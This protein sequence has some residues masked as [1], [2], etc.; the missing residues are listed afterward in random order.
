MVWILVPGALALIALLVFGGLLLADADAVVAGTVAIALLLLATGLAVNG[1][2]VTRGRERRL[3]AIADALREERADERA[4]LERHVRRLEDALS[5]ERVVLRRLRDSWRAE[6]EWSRELR[7]QLQEL[8]GRSAGRRDV[9]ELVLETAIR[10]VDAQ[11]GLLLTRQDDDDD[12]NLDL[13]TALGF[14]EDPE[15]SAV[16]QRFGREVLSE[17]QIIREDHP[18]PS[19]REATP[20]DEEIDTLVAVPLYIRD[21]FHGVIVCANRPGGF[22]EVDDEVL[23]AL[24]NHAGAALH[25]GQLGRDLRDA[26]RAVVRVLAEAVSA[27]DPVLHRESAALSLLAGELAADLGLTDDERDVLVIATLLRAV[28]YLPLPER[29]LLRPGPLTPDESALISLHPRLGYDILR[30]APALRAPATAILYHHER[31][32]GQGYPAGLQG[33]DIPIVARALAVLEAFGAM[34]HE[35]PHRGAASPERA[36]N[37]L[38]EKAGMQF[39]PEIAQL[40]VERVRTGPVH[41]GDD[42]PDAIT[43][44]LQ[45]DPA[46]LDGTSAD[47]L[48]ATTVDG[49]TLLGDHHALQRELLEAT[50]QATAERRF[51]VVLLQLQDLP[52][53]NE[54]FGYV[55]GDRLIQ[56]AARRAATV[57]TRLGATTFRA[58]GR[59]LAMQVP[60]RDGDDV[61]DILQQIRTEF[62]AGPAV[63]VVASAWRPGDRAEE[64]LGRA[65]RALSRESV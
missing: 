60:L 14:T 63:D 64:V 41:D 4:R 37:E 52:R 15:H 51:A 9:L 39:D 46:D 55:A 58:S 26:H 43:D 12:G 6:R 24:G 54:Q 57:A 28:G 50:S 49:L 38:I 17:D 65:R 20:A 3:R 13:V 61:G 18:V 25:H 32:D 29:L 53:I 31:Y 59:R 23:L 8:Y 16:V 48:S 47:P 30:Q 2:R 27:R 36:C 45:R 21:R 33:E 44:I 34:T 1:W 40:L 11:K 62:M 5:H 22:A 19:E 35:R 42:L 7:R 10:L 56:V